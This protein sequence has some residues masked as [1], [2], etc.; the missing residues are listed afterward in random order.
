VPIGDRMTLALLLRNGA[1]DMFDMIFSP[2]LVVYTTLGKLYERNF[3]DHNPFFIVL[4]IQ[5]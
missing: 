2:G 3:S 5:V 4:S 1:T